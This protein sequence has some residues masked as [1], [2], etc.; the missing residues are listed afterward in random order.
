M[1]EYKQADIAAEIEKR[2]VNGCYNDKLPSATELSDEF[3]VNIRTMSKSLSLLAKK[4]L[5][6]KKRGIGAFVNKQKTPLVLVNYRSHGD[7]RESSYH[8]M[9]WNGIKDR[10]EKLGCKL[11]LE[12][13]YQGALDCFDGIIQL[14]HGL[15]NKYNEMTRKKIPFV[16]IEHVPDIHVASVSTDVYKALYDIFGRLYRSGVQK[17]AYIGMTTSRSLTTDVRKFHAWQDATDDMLQGVEY[18]LVQHVWPLPENSYAAMKKILKREVPDVVFT[19]CD[20]MAAGIYKALREANLRIPEDVGVLGCD[21]LNI[22]LTP[23]LATVK[24]PRYE[25]G[26][27]SL[28]LLLEMIREPGRR[29]RKKISLDAEFIPGES[30]KQ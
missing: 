27:K 23:Q 1:P 12:S 10:A 8:S 17:I 30:L 16:V 28:E 5:I 11:E 15:S 21:G 4:R 29:N 13:C 3:N 6:V 20:V 9:I 18:D 7:I 25:M 26:A 19:T 24:V 22:D 14:D 2:I